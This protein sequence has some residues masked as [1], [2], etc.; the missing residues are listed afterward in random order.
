MAPTIS[1][2]VADVGP[3]RSLRFLARPPTARKIP[4]LR[5]ADLGLAAPLSRSVLPRPDGGRVGLVAFW[6]DAEALD[7]FRAEHHAGAALAD[8]WFAELEPV[9]VHGQWPDL[10]PDGIP[11][12]RR[13]EHDGPAIVL[14]LGRLR[15]SQT[16]RFLR[17]SA[18][19]QA[20]ALDASGV[21]WATGLAR[22][23]FVA[24]CS[25]WTSQG[26]LSA[27]AYGPAEHGHTD[28]IDEDQAKPFHKRSAFVRLRL[29]RVEGSLGGDNPLPVELGSSL[30]R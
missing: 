8:G 12:A 17:A 5:H 7:A 19:A 11:T 15:L 30:T 2:H 18:R 24:T 20:A 23:P 14:T 28:A 4:G 22:P 21:L 10:D 16:R 26:A 9:R 27:Y 3:A 13:V 6:D 25:L 29:L 1:V